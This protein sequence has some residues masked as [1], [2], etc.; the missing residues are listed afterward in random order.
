MLTTYR[1]EEQDVTVSWSPR[2]RSALYAIQ[3]DG[4]LLARC[5]E[6]TASGTFLILD[7]QRRPLSTFPGL[8]AAV[9]HLVRARHRR[10]PS[11]AT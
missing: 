9:E 11:V 5:V 6:Q 2:Q 1:I 7:A 10:D 8:R 4:V 3:V